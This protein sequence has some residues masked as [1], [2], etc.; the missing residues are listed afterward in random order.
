MIDK[1]EIIG[2][3]FNCIEDINQKNGSHIS[4]TVNTELFGPES[5]LDSLGLVNLIVGVEE[6]INE[7]YDISINI[8][9]ERAMSKRNSPFRSVESLT[10]H[11]LEIIK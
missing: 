5:A 4:K 11:I 9:D 3:I 7:K 6:A 8:A 2:I 10:D 1:N